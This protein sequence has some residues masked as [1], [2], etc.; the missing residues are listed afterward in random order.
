MWMLNNLKD[1][2][3]RDFSQK[4]HIYIYLQTFDFLSHANRKKKH[5]KNHSQPFLRIKCETNSLD[6]SHSSWQL[7]LQQSNRYAQTTTKTA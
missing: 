6:P 3:T 5:I 1:L 7:D 4:F 2:V